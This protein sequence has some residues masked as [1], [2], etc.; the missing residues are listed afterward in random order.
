MARRRTT[1]TQTSAT[2]F[3]LRAIR[4]NT[5][6]NVIVNSASVSD[7]ITLIKKALYVQNLRSNTRL[8]RLKNSNT[9][10]E[11]FNNRKSADNVAFPKPTDLNK[12]AHTRHSDNLM[13]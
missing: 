10:I 6:L 11:D 2:P 4:L 7:I 8:Q 13:E 1:L 3:E 5:Y 9:Q 12:S